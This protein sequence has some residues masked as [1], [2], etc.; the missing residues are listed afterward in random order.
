MTDVWF[1]RQLLW[2]QNLSE[3]SPLSLLPKQ[4]QGKSLPAGKQA[5][6]MRIHS[7]WRYCVP[8]RQQEE[9][10]EEGALWVKAWGRREM[11]TQADVLFHFLKLS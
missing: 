10:G 7:L 4:L 11:Q 6:I 3:Q 5:V 8:H 9:K 1:K 2:P